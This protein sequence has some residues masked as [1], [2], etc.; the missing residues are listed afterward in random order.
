M[1]NVKELDGTGV[2]RNYLNSLLKKCE[3]IRE[4]EKIYAS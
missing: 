3:E 4:I 2:N 1:E